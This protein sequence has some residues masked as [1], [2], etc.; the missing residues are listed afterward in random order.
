MRLMRVDDC[1][2]PSTGR[3]VNVV[4]R[5]SICFVCKQYSIMIRGKSFPLRVLCDIYCTRCAPCAPKAPWR[6]WLLCA[7]YGFW[8][9]RYEPGERFPY[10]LSPPLGWQAAQYA[11]LHKGPVCGPELC[12]M[13]QSSYIHRHTGT[14][15]H[16]HKLY[17]FPQQEVQAIYNHGGHHTPL[18]AIWSQAHIV[19][20]SVG[21]CLCWCSRVFAIST[22]CR[23]M[24]AWLY[25]LSGGLKSVETIKLCSGLL[26]NKK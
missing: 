4:M 22:E 14:H 16:T 12:I 18:F 15:A 7:L 10:V 17:S 20:S 8:T 9:S 13:E 5:Q 2:Q 19:L 26:D 21:V 25:W 23:H 3:N 1:L 11:V 6:L 24:Q